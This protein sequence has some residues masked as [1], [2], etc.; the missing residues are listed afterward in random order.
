MLLS[1]IQITE[2]S[3]GDSGRY[4]WLCGITASMMGWPFLSFI[5]I[6]FFSRTI[7]CALMWLTCEQ[8]WLF[9]WCCNWKFRPSTGQSLVRSPSSPAL[10]LSLGVVFTL[11]FLFPGLSTHHLRLILNIF[12]LL[13]HLDEWRWWSGGDSTGYQEVLGPFCEGV[14]TNLVSSVYQKTTKIW[15]DLCGL[16][17]KTHNLLQG[18]LI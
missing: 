8:E 4:I 2:F 13:F 12:N 18:L 9:G 10:P 17:I 3:E 14:F 16:M 11:Y 6:E 15:L 1:K 7:F 5:W